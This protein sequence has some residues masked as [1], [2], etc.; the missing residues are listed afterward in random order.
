MANT[1]VVQMVVGMISWTSDGIND[2]FA[3]NNDAKGVEVV[4][5][6]QCCSGSCCVTDAV[7][8]CIMS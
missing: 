6:S 5:A 4:N 3:S 1:V 8:G 7:S 2:E